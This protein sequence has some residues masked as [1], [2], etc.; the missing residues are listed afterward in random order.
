[1]NTSA[2]VLGGFLA[3]AALG[4]VA[5]ILLAPDTGANTRTKVVDESKRLTDKITESLSKSLGL[6]SKEA[7]Q[8]I[9]ESKSVLEE[10]SV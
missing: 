10:A 7:K 2:K 3:G 8:K 4:A 6:I 9:E 5:G 1:M